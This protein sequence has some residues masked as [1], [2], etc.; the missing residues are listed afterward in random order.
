[1]RFNRH[2]VATDHLGTGSEISSNL[3]AIDRQHHKLTLD[4]ANALRKSNE[5]MKLALNALQF[6]NERAGH[7]GAS[8]DKVDAAINT[9][10]N[11]A[12]SQA[13]SKP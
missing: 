12:S 9:G 3:S 1:M 7:V 11:E 4:A 8:L 5:K 13:E 2:R 10:L 6:T